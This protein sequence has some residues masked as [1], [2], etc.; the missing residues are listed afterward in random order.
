[1][2]VLVTQL[3]P[4]PAVLE[5]QVWRRT[6]KGRGLARAEGVLDHLIGETRPADYLT[7]PS[8]AFLVPLF[9]I[10]EVR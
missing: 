3:N 2:V 5:S 8:F 1:M 10:T 4:V 6:I 7:L 9:E